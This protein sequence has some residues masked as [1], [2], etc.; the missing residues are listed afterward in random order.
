MEYI[1]VTNGKGEK[2]HIPVADVRHSKEERETVSQMVKSSN[3]NNSK[4]IP[5]KYGYGTF[6]PKKY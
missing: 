5:H 1:N 4:Y 2:F 6:G 3:G